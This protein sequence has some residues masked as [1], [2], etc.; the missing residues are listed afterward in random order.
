MASKNESGKIVYADDQYVNRQA[1]KMAIQDMGFADRL[2]LCSNGQ[3]VLDYLD[4]MLEDLT[5]DQKR[6]T[7]F[8]P[9]SLL[10]LDVNMPILHGLDTL[11]LV[12]Q[13]FQDA[14]HRLP[15]LRPVICYL[16][17]FDGEFKQFIREEEEAECYLEKPLSTIELVN[18]LKLLRFC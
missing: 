18:L 9:V 15:V 11:P 8:Q 17:Q 10:L 3:E 2:V 5:L 4:K 1:F 16:T 6:T 14:N 7:A 13:K 12:K